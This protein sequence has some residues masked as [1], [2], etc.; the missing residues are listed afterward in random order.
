MS[1]PFTGIAL[2]IYKKASLYKR[3][4]FKQADGTY[5]DFSSFDENGLFADA[6]D[7]SGYPVFET[8][9]ELNPTFSDAANGEIQL[10]VTSVTTTAISNNTDGF[11]DAQLPIWDLFV[12]DGAGIVFKLMSGTVAVEDS[13]ATP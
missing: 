2:T 3:W 10:L 12:T 9:L 1:I 7:V 11:T 13:Q 6:V 4:R 5:Y 8:S